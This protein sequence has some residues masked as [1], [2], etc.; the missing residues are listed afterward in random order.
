MAELKKEKLADRIKLHKMIEIEALESKGGMV[1]GK[2]YKVGEE[3]AKTLVDSKRAKK[4]G[5][6]A[7]AAK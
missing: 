2:K 6:K 3:L 5:E 7:P 4:V 1:K